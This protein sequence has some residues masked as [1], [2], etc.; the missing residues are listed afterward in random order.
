MPAQSK[1]TEARRK[2][3]L[4]ALRYGASHRTAAAEA[5]IGHQTLIRWLDQGKDA[6]PDSRF[7]KFYGEVQAAEAHPIMRALR[8]VY[9]EIPED[10]KLAFKLL[11][12]REKGY[13]PPMPTGP[14]PVTG[15]LVIQIALNDGRQAPMTVIEGEA[16]DVPNVNALPAPSD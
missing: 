16:V 8:S 1:F 5:G 2:V 15:P 11:E 9:R 12:R 13:A 14:P 7:G 3:I 6:D 10:P 4:E